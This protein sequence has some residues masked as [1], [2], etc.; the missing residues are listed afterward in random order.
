MPQYAGTGQ[1]QLARS[2][3]E[4]FLFVNELVQP[5]LINASRAFFLD[6]VTP[7]YAQA[8]FSVEILFGGDPGTFQFD[9]EGAEMDRE[10]SYFAVGGSITAVNASFA[11]RFDGTDYP[12]FVRGRVV[13]VTAPIMLTAVLVL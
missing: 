2:N 6:R 3:S 10:G 8:R 13:N 9:V 11:A 4:N 12:K 7:G 5:G 1:A